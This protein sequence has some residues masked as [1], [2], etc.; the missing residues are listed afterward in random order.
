MFRSKIFPSTDWS[1]VR[2][3]STQTSPQV[4]LL[5]LQLKVI[6]SVM[7]LEWSAR[8]DRYMD[9]LQVWLAEVLRALY[10]LIEHCVSYKV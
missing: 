9:P 6:P 2:G 4:S 3:G 5:L 1:D 10:C 7:S 8:L